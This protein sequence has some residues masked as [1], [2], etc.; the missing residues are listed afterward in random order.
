MPVV[1]SVKDPTSAPPVSAALSR[2]GFDDSESSHERR[3]ERSHLAKSPIPTFWPAKINSAAVPAS[4]TRKP[5]DVIVFGGK[6]GGDAVAGG[7]GAGDG[8]EGGGGPASDGVG[9]DGGGGFIGGVGGGGGGRGG[10][11]GGGGNGA[12]AMRVLIVG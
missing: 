3:S 8:S 9:R 12:A 6:F 10:S 11:A 5:G 7:G 1:R 4:T 2:L